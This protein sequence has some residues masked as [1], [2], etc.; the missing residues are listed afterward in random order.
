MRFHEK[1]SYNHFGGTEVLQMTDAPMPTGEIIVKVKAVSINPLD[2]KLWQGDMKL[3]SGRKFPKSVGIDFAGI[4]EQ[5]NGKI[6]QRRRS[7]RY[8]RYI[9]RRGPCGIYSCKSLRYCAAKPK[10]N[11]LRRSSWPSCC[12]LGCPADLQY[13]GEYTTGYAA[14]D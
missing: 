5:G 3:M 9:Q 12:R 10:V 6:S 14:P 11:H 1:I 8:G 4:V 13:P 2:W 7:I